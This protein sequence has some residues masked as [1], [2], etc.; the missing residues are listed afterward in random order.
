MIGEIGVIV[1]ASQN[2][3]GPSEALVVNKS[4]VDR[5]SEKETEDI[6]RREGGRA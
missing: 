3:K 6:L 1:G 5:R 2:V 4:I